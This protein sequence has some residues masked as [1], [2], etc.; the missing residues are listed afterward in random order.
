M[1]ANRDHL[2]LV[3][4]MF[5]TGLG[6]ARSLGRN[7]IIVKGLDHKR[8]IGFYS[9]HVRAKICPNPIID[10]EGFIEYLLEFGRKHTVKPAVFITSDDYLVAIARNISRL[11]DWFLF[12][13]PETDLILTIYDKYKQYQLAEAGGNDLPQT[14]KI[15]RSDEIES[16]ANELQFPAI[17]K[18]LKVNS[19]RQ[20]IS[21]T[22]KVF[23]VFSRSEFISQAISLL[24]LQ[25]DCLVQEIIQGPDSNHYKFCACFSKNGDMIHGFTLRTIRQNPIRFGVGS[26]VESIHSKNVYDAGVKLFHSINY[27]GVGSAEFKLDIKDNKL[28]LIEINPRYWQ[29]NALT[30]AC[31]INFPLTDY[32]EMTDQ[33]PVPQINYITGIKWVNIYMDFNSFMNYR[34][35]DELTL[36]Q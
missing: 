5:E 29:Q 11:N 28:K 10:E 1:I 12:N 23:E 35:R 6:V 7:G 17:I 21:H 14:Y 22:K 9:K 13:L 26:V 18:G 15:T 34:K 19:W 3:L 8:D 33:N 16:V 25:V 2:A 31:G 20:E 24:N 4:G 32:L 36:H 30:D 27:R